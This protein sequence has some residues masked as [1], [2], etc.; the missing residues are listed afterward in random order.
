MGSRIE[1]CHKMYV[2][3]H[4]VKKRFPP[5][6]D[7]ESNLRLLRDQ[8]S[9][10]IHN[11]PNTTRRIIVQFYLSF[12]IQIVNLDFVFVEGPATEYPEKEV[13]LCEWHPFLESRTSY[14]AHTCSSKG[15]YSTS[16]VQELL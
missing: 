3:A 12:S 13:R 8:I 4:G 2:D 1:L 7:N 5:Y 15:K 10:H 6:P 11:V 9:R 14:M 16:I